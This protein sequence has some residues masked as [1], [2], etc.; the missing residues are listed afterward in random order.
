MRKNKKIKQIPEFKN[1]DEEREFW[2]THDLTDYLDHFQP[3]EMDLSELKPSTRPVTIRLP[4]SLWSAL[5]TLANKKDV[6]YQSLM[7]IFLS[8]KVKEE[9]QNKN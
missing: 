3:V 9:F 8:E 6:P 7:K 5:K 1:E 4:E 2:A